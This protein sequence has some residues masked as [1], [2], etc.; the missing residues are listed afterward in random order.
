VS[1]KRSDGQT[2]ELA[3]LTNHLRAERKNYVGNDI[4]HRKQYS[5]GSVTSHNRVRSVTSFFY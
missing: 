2:D 5:T 1:E 4:R 3:A